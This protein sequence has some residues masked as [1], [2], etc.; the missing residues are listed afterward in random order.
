LTG[1]VALLF[2]VGFLAVVYLDAPLWFPL[3]FALVIM[4]LQYAFNPRIIEWLVPANIIPTHEGGYATEHRVGALLAERCR[5][6]GVPFV[7]L[8]IVDDGTP[9]AFTFGRTRRD[10]RVWLTRGLFERLD[11]HE[12]DAVIA[13]EI[14]HVKNR[15]FIVMTIAAVVPMILYFVYLATRGRRDQVGAVAVAAYVGY[16]VSQFTLLALSRA[17]EYAADH[18]S[19]TAT[20]NGD[21]LCSALVKIAYGMG[22]VDATRQNE[23]AAA[24]DEAKGWRERMKEKQNRQ[25]SEAKVLR[26]QSMRAMGIFEPRTAVALETALA[27]GVDPDRA[28]AAMRWDVVNPWA[29][30]LEKMSSHPLVVRR[31]QALEA[32]SLPGKPT[33]WSVLRAMAAVSPEQRLQARA[34]F[35]LQFAIAAAPWAILV[36]LVAF[37]AFRQSAFTIGAAIA[38]AGFLLLIKQVMRYPTDFTPAANVTSLLDRLDASPVAGVAIELKGRIVGRGMPGYLLSPDLVIQDESGFVPVFY[39]NSLPFARLAFGLARAKRFLGKEVTVRG[40]YRRVP[41]PAVDLRDV[42]TTDG[43]RA[44]G[45]DWIL[46]YAAST[47]VMFV[48][49]GILLAGSGS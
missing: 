45:W 3:F 39:S 42:H 8:G 21:A 16:L 7:K 25:K 17:R 4:G 20:A 14:G 48:G 44:K 5:Q 29:K 30:V 19:C 41:G 11:E 46:R 24:I 26:M 18:W 22:H 47:I 35:A 10:A 28:I 9:N 31:F 34:G 49:A 12:L 27:A 6:A 1:L 37:G 38:G 15:D 33:R 23:A 2:G 36:P 40:W 43:L 13:H 32:T